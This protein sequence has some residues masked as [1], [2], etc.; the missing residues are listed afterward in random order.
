M[1]RAHALSMRQVHVVTIQQNFYSPTLSQS[2]C[3][4]SNVIRCHFGAANGWSTVST[5]Y[6]FT[7]FSSQRRLI[8]LLFNKQLS[9]TRQA[10]V[11]CQ[12]NDKLNELSSSTSLESINVFWLFGVGISC[13]KL[14]DALCQ[15]QVMSNVH[16]SQA[17]VRIGKTSVWYI[18]ILVGNERYRSLQILHLCPSK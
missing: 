14:P 9:V 16:V 1:Y 5:A 17:C 12:I 10:L 11:K 2:A 4:W 6:D 15:Q 18:R 7:Y 13:G 8:G 3:W